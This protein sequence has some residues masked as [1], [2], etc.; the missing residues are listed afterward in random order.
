MINYDINLL[1][2]LFLIYAYGIVFKVSP[3]RLCVPLSKRGVCE[4]RILVSLCH[5]KLICRN[6]LVIISPGVLENREYL[7]VF[8]KKYQICEKGDLMD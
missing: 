4:I 1:F 5:L 3:S 2:F 8:V 6:F 7:G